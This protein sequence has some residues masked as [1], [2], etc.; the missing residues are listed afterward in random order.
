MQAELRT[1]KRLLQISPLDSENLKLSS[2]HSGLHLQQSQVTE[3]WHCPVDCTRGG[4]ISGR[5]P[6]FKSA[7]F[8][9]KNHPQKPLETGTQGGDL[10]SPP[11][12]FLPLSHKDGKTLKLPWKGTPHCLQFWDKAL[13]RRSRF[14]REV[15]QSSTR[16]TWWKI[17][18]NDNQRA[19]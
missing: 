3:P 5:S 19:R 4:G 14:P 18:A 10:W 2:L 12:A 6:P 17:S 15:F 8:A 1:G 16:P 13:A 7:F 11:A 9:C